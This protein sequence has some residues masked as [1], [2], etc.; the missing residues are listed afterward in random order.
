MPRESGRFR[1][2]STTSK[3]RPARWPS[4][5]SSLGATIS[6][7]P[8]ERRN[9][10]TRD[11]YASSSSSIRICSGEAVIFPSVE[12]LR[13]LL[14]HVFDDVLQARGVG[15]RDARERAVRLEDRLAPCLR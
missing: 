5:I 12:S 6:S 13:L 2:D 14:L 7:L 4:A 1:S 8:L 10:C 11:A 9:R 15:G 3:R